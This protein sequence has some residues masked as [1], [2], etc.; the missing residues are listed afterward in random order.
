MSSNWPSALPPHTSLVWFRL[1]GIPLTV[2]VRSIPYSSTMAQLTRLLPSKF[3]PKPI[4]WSALPPRTPCPHSAP[5]GLV[6]MPP[7]VSSWALPGTRPH[8]CL[9][10]CPHHK[11]PVLWTRCFPSTRL[12]WTG[13]RAGHS[14]CRAGWACL[15]NQQRAPSIW[16]PPAP[17]GEPTPY[18]SL[19]KLVGLV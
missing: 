10:L 13:H 17:L 16:D 3:P 11:A 5:E 8:L 15:G 6:P 19:L 1:Q 4:F 7:P 2:I 9:S 12:D 18:L 14:S